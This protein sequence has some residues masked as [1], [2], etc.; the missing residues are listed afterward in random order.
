MS[1]LQTNDTPAAEPAQAPPA[2]VSIDVP[3]EHASIVS[4]LLAILKSGERWV[5]DNVE[6]GIGHFENLLTPADEEAPKE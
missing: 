1:D 3:P 2:T 5:I 6:A 4:R